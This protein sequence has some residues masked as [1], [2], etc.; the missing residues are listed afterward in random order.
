MQS[1]VSEEECENKSNKKPTGYKYN[2]V[3][4]L[5]LRPWRRGEVRPKRR[6]PNELHGIITKEIALFI[7]TAVQISYHKYATVSSYCIGSHFASMAKSARMPEMS[8]MYI[9]LKRLINCSQKTKSLRVFDIL[10]HIPK[11]PKKTY[12]FINPTTVDSSN[13]SVVP[14]C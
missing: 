1:D 5:L 9:W 4:N 13:C 3:S 6:A 10:Y 14:M 2:Q 12:F 7:V 8:T 11:N